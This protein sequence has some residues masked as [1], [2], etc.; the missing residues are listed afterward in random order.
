MFVLCS[1]RL[2]RRCWRLFRS[3]RGLGGAG[4]SPGWFWG[5]A[6]AGRSKGGGGGKRAGASQDRGKSIPPHSL[7]PSMDF[8]W[9]WRK[10]GR[11]VLCN[12]GLKL[13]VACAGLSK[14]KVFIKLVFNRNCGIL[15]IGR[16]IRIT[17]MMRRCSRCLAARRK[18]ASGRA[19]ETRE[20]SCDAGSC[21][22]P[23]KKYGR[24]A[25]MARAVVSQVRI[26]DLPQEAWS[27]PDD[28]SVAQF[29]TEKDNAR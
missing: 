9:G 6:A 16:T 5:V 10:T 17:V 14:F 13:S 12:P 28:V 19:A 18:R 11:V 29:L 1:Y 3:P 20:A 2:S 21:P 27:L 25:Q 26:L 15:I 8:V 7:L 22:P 24:L 4:R 23:P